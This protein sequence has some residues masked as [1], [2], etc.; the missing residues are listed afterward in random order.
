MKKLLATLMA[1]TLTV[2]LAACGSK[3]PVKTDSVQTKPVTETVKQEQAKKYGVET[4]TYAPIFTTGTSEVEDAMINLCG[5]YEV[6]QGSTQIEANPE[7]K[8]AFDK[9]TEC[10]AGATYE[11]IAYLGKQIVA[12]TNYSF[13]CR[14][15]PSY[16][17]CKGKFVVVVIYQNLEG[18]AEVTNVSDIDISASGNIIE[19]AEQETEPEY[20]VYDGSCE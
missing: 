14:M 1:A 5:A 11:P 3:N 7:A 6:N 10:L 9:A 18:N 19:E 17:G 15:T 8:A 13:L 20:G 12:G 2:S 4:G 16:S